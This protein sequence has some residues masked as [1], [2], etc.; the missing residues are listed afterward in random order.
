MCSL[1]VTEPFLPSPPVTQPPI[2]PP[3]H[4]HP[5]IK[6]HAK[7]HPGSALSGPNPQ[8]NPYRTFATM[9]VWLRSYTPPRS[10]PNT[11]IRL[12]LTYPSGQEI[13]KKE[14]KKERTY[15]F[16]QGSPSATSLGGSGFVRPLTKS[17]QVSKPRPGQQGIEI[18][19]QRWPQ[20]KS[21]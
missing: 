15:H 13:R 21:R 10:L 1:P 5:H 16:G 7:S 18:V 2:L 12:D 4:P 20:W 3:S 11:R 6:Q 9:R 19:A 14:R 8:R 17:G